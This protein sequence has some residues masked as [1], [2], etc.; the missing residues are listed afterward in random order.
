VRDYLRTCGFLA[1]NADLNLFIG[2][3]VSIL[4]YDDNMLVIKK[5]RD[6]DTAKVLIS[7]K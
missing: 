6:L 3:D 2:K 7:Q 5:H 1:L 4:L